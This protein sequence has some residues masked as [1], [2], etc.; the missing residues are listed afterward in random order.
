[1]QSV[2]D[3]ASC[4]HEAG[5]QLSSSE[6]IL[7]VNAC[8]AM[9]DQVAPRR[10]TPADEPSTQ[11]QFTVFEGNPVWLLSV[12]EIQGLGFGFYYDPDSA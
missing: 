11:V 6:E 7:T 3:L 4:S 2:S 12:P 5:G 10:H 9:G 8:S 1:M